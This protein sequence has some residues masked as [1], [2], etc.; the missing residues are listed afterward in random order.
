MGV[1]VI[2]DINSTIECTKNK[3]HEFLKRFY[4][5]NNDEKFILINVLLSHILAL[6]VRDQLNKGNRSIA[7]KVGKIEPVFIKIDSIMYMYSNKVNIIKVIKDIH[8]IRNV[9]VHDYPTQMAIKSLNYIFEKD[10]AIR[11]LCN[12]L[13]FQM[14]E[15]PKLS[16]EDAINYMSGSR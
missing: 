13:G 16:F 8:R 2:F 15:K 6:Y 3:I 7:E 4:S 5:L 1:A 9:V 12:E 14:Q 10:D 11:E